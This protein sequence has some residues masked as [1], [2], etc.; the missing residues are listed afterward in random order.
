MKRIAQLVMSWKLCTRTVELYQ[1]TQNAT[2]VCDM[3]GLCPNKEYVRKHESGYSLTQ[4]F[5]TYRVQCQ[6]VTGSSNELHQETGVKRI[7]NVNPRKPPLNL[8]VNSR[9]RLKP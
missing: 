7:K 9:S 8:T 5:Q 1:R 2:N 4:K 6:M 3:Q